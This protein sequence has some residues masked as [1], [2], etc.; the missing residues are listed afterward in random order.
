MRYIP[1]DWYC[2]ANNILAILAMWVFSLVIFFGIV[3]LGT[4]YSRGNSEYILE[5]GA[6]AAEKN[7]KKYHP[8]IYCELVES[9]CNCFELGVKE[10]DRK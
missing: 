1:K 7:I 8:K 5:I 2:R 10:H 4:K 9:K 6:K 3:F